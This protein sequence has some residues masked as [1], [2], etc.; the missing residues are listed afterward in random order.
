MTRRE[1]RR[2]TH[3][4]LRSGMPK[5]QVFREVVAQG[6]A[7]HQVAFAITTYPDPKLREMHSGKVFALIVVLLAISLF[8]GFNASQAFGGTSDTTGYL[9]VLQALLA[10][11]FAGGIFSDKYIA[12]VLLLALSFSDLLGGL[13]IFKQ[14]PLATLI[15]MGI[16]IVFIVYVYWVMKKIF[17]GSAFWWRRS[18]GV[19]YV[20]KE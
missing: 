8:S 4:L 20:F 1:A 12:Y 10:L 9:F 18:G 16:K 2:K 5:N 17:P 15:S 7:E 19:G 13:F 11:I 3:E 6:G 14:A